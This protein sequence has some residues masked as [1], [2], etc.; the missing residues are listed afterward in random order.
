M[1]QPHPERQLERELVDSAAIEQALHSEG[2]IRRMHQPHPERQLERE[3]VDSAAIEQMLQTTQL[4]LG[5]CQ[6]H[7]GEIIQGMFYDNNNQKRRALV[8]LPCP[9]FGT[10]AKF[11][12]TPQP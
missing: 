6:A 12:P 7:H 9:I 3:F 5:S 10:T 11:L 1:H 8:T 4:G 2:D